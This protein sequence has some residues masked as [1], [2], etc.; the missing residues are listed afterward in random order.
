[1]TV[2][3][4]REVG[5]GRRAESNKYEHILLL[6]DR[7]CMVMADWQA[8]SEATSPLLFAK[9]KTGQPVQDHGTEELAHG[10]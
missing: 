4:V 9:A 7:T 8:R 5:G 10:V 6:P 2:R 1:V 3:W